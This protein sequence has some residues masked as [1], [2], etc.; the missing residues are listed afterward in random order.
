MAWPSDFFCY[1]RNS[2]KTITK[3]DFSIQWPTWE[4]KN[5]IL[6][7]YLKIKNKNIYWVC[8]RRQKVMQI[9]HLYSYDNKVHKYSSTSSMMTF[10]P[11]S[12]A[13]A[14]WAGCLWPGA[15]AQ[16]G[17]AY[18]WAAP[19]VRI[20]PLPSCRTPSRRHR[21]SRRPVMWSEDPPVDNIK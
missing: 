9:C 4:Y 14:R 20:A 19:L 5:F 8:E 1:I 10:S 17:R 7:C 15:E 3:Q 6:K 11:Q 16:P 12:R 21:R 2:T 18:V 13:G